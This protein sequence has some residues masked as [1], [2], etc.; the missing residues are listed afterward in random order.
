ML[1]WQEDDRFE[2]ILNINVEGSFSGT[3][4]RLENVT[5]NKNVLSLEEI[6]ENNRCLIFAYDSINFGISDDKF[7][8]IKFITRL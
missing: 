1:H 5:L 2:R 8:F 3:R 6:A 4:I 7:K